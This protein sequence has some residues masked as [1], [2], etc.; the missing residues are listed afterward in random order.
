MIIHFIGKNSKK[1]ILSGMSSVLNTLYDMGVD[2]FENAS[3]SIDLSIQG[4]RVHLLQSQSECTVTFEQEKV[5]IERLLNE[6]PS[7]EQK[8]S[9]QDLDF[10]QS[11]DIKNSKLITE[12][13]KKSLITDEVIERK[14][15]TLMKAFERQW[16][17]TASKE[18]RKLLGIGAK[19]YNERLSNVSLLKMKSKIE[20]YGIY[21]EHEVVRVAVRSKDLTT[22]TSFVFDSDCH[23]LYEGPTL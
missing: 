9:V 17:S 13:E 20:T 6:T 12:T 14:N 21:G 8:K 22:I 2:S 19:E 1:R 15:E 23:L 7:I 18:A 5:S 10:Y 3:I 16:K 4:N 11:I